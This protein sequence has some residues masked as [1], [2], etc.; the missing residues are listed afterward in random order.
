MPEVKVIYGSSNGNTRAAAEKIAEALGGKAVNV[1]GATSDDFNADLLILGTSTW[2]FGDL[3]DDWDTR[4]D[5]LDR[6]DLKDRKVALFGLGDQCGF[7]DS[8][9]DGVKILYDKVTASGAMV[10]GKW[11]SSGYQHNT[12]AA[13]ENGCF[14]GLA[15]D[16]DNESQQSA[17]RIDKWCGQLRLEAGI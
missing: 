10:I 12:S 1:A 15:L 9:I 17:E 7:C 5:M 14:L 3:Q 6:I 2:G 11:S 8:F 16:E 4:I 13:E